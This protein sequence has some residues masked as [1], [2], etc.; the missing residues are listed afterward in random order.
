MAELTI[1]EKAARYDALQV[2][3]DI[4]IDIYKRR[5]QDA[6]AKYIDTTIIGVYNKGLADAYKE[7]IKTLRDF[8]N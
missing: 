5:E 7:T 1:K 3:I 6:K 8:K 2:A 4:M